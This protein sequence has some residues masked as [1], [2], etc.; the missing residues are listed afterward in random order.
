MNL[1]EMYD[2]DRTMHNFVQDILNI[3]FDYTLI[4]MGSEAPN[5]LGIDLGDRKSKIATQ[6]T[7]VNTSQK[8]NDTL[9]KILFLLH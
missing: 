7:A 1:L 4:N 5:Y 8:I 3:L 9:K 6:V 2:I